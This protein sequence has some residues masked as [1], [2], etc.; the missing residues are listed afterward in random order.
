MLTQM[1]ADPGMC[2]FSDAIFNLKSHKLW[3]L[4]FNAVSQK[5]EKFK[6]WLKNTTEENFATAKV[7]K[8]NASGSP[9]KSYWTRLCRNELSESKDMYKVWKRLKK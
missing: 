7:L 5:K 6:K 2:S 4:V 1:G 9:K 8:Y 3:S